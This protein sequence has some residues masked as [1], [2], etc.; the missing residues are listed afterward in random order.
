MNSR[1]TSSTTS[2][3][4]H[5]WCLPK[6]NE[7]LAELA[8][9]ILTSPLWNW[10]V[11]T[12]ICQQPATI[13]CVH[14]HIHALDRYLPRICTN[15]NK[16]WRQLQS[17]ICYCM[18][19]NTSLQ[20]PT[21]VEQQSSST[22]SAQIREPHQGMINIPKPYKEQSYQRPMPLDLRPGLDM[23]RYYHH[24]SNHF[25]PKHTGRSTKNIIVWLQTINNMQTTWSSWLQSPLDP[26]YLPTRTGRFNPFTMR[27]GLTHQQKHKSQQVVW[28]Y[29]TV[30][31]MVNGEQWPPT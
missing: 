1:T 3:N 26:H 9:R 4:V 6:K 23:N 5:L 22:T 19:I 31:T 14:G 24:D 11:G 17:Y 16:L 8:P 12:G 21:V 15:N 29:G 27:F 30:F 25:K 28:S 20:R 18:S 2:S 13:V 10:V 7:Q